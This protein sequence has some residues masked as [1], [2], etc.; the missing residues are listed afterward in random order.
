MK[1]LALFVSPEQQANFTKYIPYGPV[2]SKA[3]DTGIITPEAAKLINSSPENA[4]NQIIADSN[5]WG[6][7]GAK[8]VEMW[9][10][11]RQ[12]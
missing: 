10:N 11:F 3:F 8:V 5:W 6:E 7:N 2:N 1:A 9:D 12:K 4:K